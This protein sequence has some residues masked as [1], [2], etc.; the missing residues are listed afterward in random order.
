MK[1]LDR[2][3]EF[4]DASHMKEVH[5][6]VAKNPDL[7]KLHSRFDL[8]ISGKAGLSRR[9]RISASPTI[10]CY[11]ID[12]AFGTVPLFYWTRSVVTLL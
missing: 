3:R 10:A 7:E 11:G 9:V 5:S 1:T 4:K 8:L 2:D 6:Q 12:M